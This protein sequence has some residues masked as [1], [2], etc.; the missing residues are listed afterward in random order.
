MA[1]I[2]LK[3]AVISG[4]ALLLALLTARYVRHTISNSA[5]TSADPAIASQPSTNQTLTRSGN[6][7]AGFFSRTARP[8]NPTEAAEA[9][10]LDQLREI[11]YSTESDI[12][13]PPEG[14]AAAIAASG[15]QRGAALGLMLSARRS[16]G[17]AKDRAP[18]GQQVLAAKDR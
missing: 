3:T 2:K 15:S 6:G 14:M 10:A 7:I 16:L 4:I 17:S 9:A 5:E 13:L 8:T 12:G 1:H 11:L 18:R